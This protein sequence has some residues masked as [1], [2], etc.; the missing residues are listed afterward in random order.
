MGFSAWPLATSFAKAL[1]ITLA[2]T[3]IGVPI[4]FTEYPQ[5]SSLATELWTPCCP[6]H[7]FAIRNS[8]ISEVYTHTYP[9]FRGNRLRHDLGTFILL[10]TLMAQTIR[11]LKTENQPGTEQKP[12][13]HETDTKTASQAPKPKAQHKNPAG[14]QNEP[15]TPRNE[16]KSSR[17]STKA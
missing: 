2:G 17:A 5:P 14:K 3:Q 10:S 15:R 12:T 16:H 4:C 7:Y 9:V 1:A 11:T 8:L 6:L 13:P